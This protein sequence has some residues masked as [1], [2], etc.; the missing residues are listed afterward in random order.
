MTE[1][2]MIKLR[3]SGIEIDEE[4][5]KEKIGEYMA[6]YEKIKKYYMDMPKEYLV[7]LIMKQ[8]RVIKKVGIELK[9]LQCK[10]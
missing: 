8:D 2:M 3:N 9:A 4:E 10:E 5:F 1:E 7:K 6:D